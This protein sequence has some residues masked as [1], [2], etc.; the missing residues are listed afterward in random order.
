MDVGLFIDSFENQMMGLESSMSD[1][2]LKRSKLPDKMKMK[3]ASMLKFKTTLL[4]SISGFLPE[5][6]KLG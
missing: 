6:A 3:T 4:K 5:V 1:I 2:L